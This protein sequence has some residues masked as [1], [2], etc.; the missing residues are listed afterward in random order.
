MH[1]MQRK[2]VQECTR[3]RVIIHVHEHSGAR[4]GLVFEPDPTNQTEE[5]GVADTRQDLDRAISVEM[6]ACQSPAV[7]M[8]PR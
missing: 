4:L 3:V 8:R 1:R 2:F 7:E 6:Q 5:G